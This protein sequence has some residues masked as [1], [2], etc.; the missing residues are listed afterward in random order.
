MLAKRITLVLLIAYSLASYADLIIP[1]KKEEFLD[2]FFSSNEK[3]SLL[4]VLIGII[5][6]IIVW[7]YIKEK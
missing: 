1:N 3:L 4:L 6:L 5:I 7:R 2:G